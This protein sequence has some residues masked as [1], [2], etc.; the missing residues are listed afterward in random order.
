MILLALL[1]LI[2]ESFILKANAQS[3]N[4]I[5]NEF[6]YDPSGTDLNYEWIELY[7][8]SGLDINLKDWKIQVAGT[9]FV[10]A[11]TFTDVVIK[12]HEY[13][14]VCERSV[15]NC[16]YYVDKIG[17]Q[18]GGD[19]TDAVQ[20]IDAKGNIVDTV[21]YDKPNKN[22][23]KDDSGNTASDEMTSTKATN[24]QS[25]GRK[26]LI[27]TDDNDKDFYVFKNPTPKEE[28]P[29]DDQLENT[30]TNVL[31]VSSIVVIFIIFLSSATLLRINSKFIFKS[32]GQS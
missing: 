21:L 5:I 12:S 24:G 4:V 23:L 10:P 3:S 17:M 7:N 31:L 22:L 14:T 30:G 1:I 27:D 2:N 6:V 9:S 20:L 32:H 11:F 28:N 18:N 25:I 15:A 29:L 13:F 16:S 26:N 8:I 19:A